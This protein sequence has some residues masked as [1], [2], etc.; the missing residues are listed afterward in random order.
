MPKGK[1]ILLFVEQLFFRV[2]N[3]VVMKLLKDCFE[4]LG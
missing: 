1:F 3:T 2:R 4:R